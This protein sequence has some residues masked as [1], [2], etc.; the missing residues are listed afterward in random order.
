MKSIVNK[1]AGVRCQV[2]HP[3]YIG[4]VCDTDTNTLHLTDTK[5]TPVKRLQERDVKN[6]DTSMTLQMTPKT[7]SWCQMPND[8][9][10]D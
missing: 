7:K 9:K 2:S 8:T 6:V 10:N 1:N 5:V 4:G 3:P